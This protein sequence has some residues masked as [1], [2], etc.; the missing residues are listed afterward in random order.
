VLVKCRVFPRT[1]ESL[2]RQYL[3]VNFLSAPIVAVLL[4]LATRAINSSVLKRGILGADGVQPINIMALFISLVHGL[5]L[6]WVSQCFG[7]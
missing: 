7:S 4:L 3:P 2:R 1:S 6:V 5:K